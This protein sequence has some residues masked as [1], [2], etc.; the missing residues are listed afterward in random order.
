MNNETKV[1][2]FLNMYK[3]LCREYGVYIMA[4][5]NEAGSEIGLDV[6]I[7]TTPEEIEEHLKELEEGDLTF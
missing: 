5:S 4:W 6:D 1:K 7:A 3:E 2:D